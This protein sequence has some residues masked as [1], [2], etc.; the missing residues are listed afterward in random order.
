MVP[1]PSGGKPRSLGTGEG[2]EGAGVSSRR[3]LCRWWQEA[4]RRRFTR[5]LLGSGLA[6][7]GLLPMP[8]AAGTPG[9]A[10]RPAL[11]LLP[12]VNSMAECGLGVL[13]ALHE[14][15]PW[16]CVR[17]CVGGGALL[18]GRGTRGTRVRRL[19]PG[20]CEAIRLRRQPVAGGEAENFQWGPDMV[21]IV[22]QN[23]RGRQPG[24]TKDS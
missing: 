15:L 8:P 14:E 17:V 6:F 16:E 18:P 21:T 23:N 24:A 4:R 11:V 1:V 20:L 12:C 22:V 3:L 7:P 10:A 19:L 5:R 13:R 9:S 2:P